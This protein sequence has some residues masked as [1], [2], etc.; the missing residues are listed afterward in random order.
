MFSYKVFRQG[1]DVLLAVSDSDLLGKTLNE[2]DL[3]VRVDEGFYSEKSSDNEEE[4]AELM[5]NATIVNAIGEK[6]IS[7]MIKR[8]FIDQENIL[9]IEGVPHAQVIKLR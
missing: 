9:R 5:A 3:A 7:L 2:N 1:E 4:I 8:K 6:T